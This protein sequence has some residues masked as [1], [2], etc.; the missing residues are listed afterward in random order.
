M[1]LQLTPR[2]RFERTTCAC[3]E[4]KLACRHMPGA[5]IPGDAEAIAGHLGVQ[6]T[7]EW[8]EQHF[9]ASDGAKVVLQGNFLAVPSMVP[10]QKADG[11]CTF[12]DDDGRCTVHPVAPF[13]CAYLDMHMGQSEA[14]E[15]S[16]ATIRAQL[17]DL[18]K[19]GDHSKH[20]A[21][22]AEKGLVAPPLFERRR[23]LENA[24]EEV[25]A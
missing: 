6:A 9:R 21:N 8:I 11:S 3:N 20:I 15:R 18:A 25:E 1:N 23:N 10:A 7:D 13:G 2:D 24:F 4:C 12:L 19:Q 22:L 16:Q 5:L 14:D 17:E